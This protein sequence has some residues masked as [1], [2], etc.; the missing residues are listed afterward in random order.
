MPWENIQH[1]E[2][3]GRKLKKLGKAVWHFIWEE[4]SILSWIVNI[5]LAFII[6]KFLVYP[7]LGFALGTTHPIVAVVSGSMEHDAS[8]DD[9]WQSPSCCT[10]NGCDK[11]ISQS[12]IY[13]GY[14]IDKS[15][16]AEFSYVDGFNK[17]D[18]MILFGPKN[19]AIGNILVFMADNRA[20]PIIHRVVGAEEIDGNVFYKTKGDHNCGSADFEKKVSKNNLVGK[21]VWRVPFLGWIKI[22]FVE[23]LKLVGIV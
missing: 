20:D 10:S 7:G 11:K 21:A 23:A 12:E 3:F 17:G 5:I 15:E 18:I 2:S 16:F 1:K 8:F 9:W 22:G 13:S 4:D 6:I 19:I 14:G